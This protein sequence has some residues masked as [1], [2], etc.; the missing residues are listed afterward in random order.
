MRALVATLPGALV[1]LLLAMPCWRKG[2]AASERRD[3]LL[4]AG[5]CYTSIVLRGFDYGEAPWVCEPNDEKPLAGR[6]K[7]AQIA[8]NQFAIQ[9]GQRFNK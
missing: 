1:T 9:F 2:P 8:A 4:E 6:V 7:W 5:F 3:P